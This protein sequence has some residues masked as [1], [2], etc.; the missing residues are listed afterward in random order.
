MD[1]ALMVSVRL[2]WLRRHMPDGHLGWL[3]WLVASH[4]ARRDRV[5][6]LGMCC[7]E[8]E[9]WHGYLAVQIVRHV[10]NVIQDLA[11]LGD[12]EVLKVPV[13][14]RGGDRDGFAGKQVL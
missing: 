2:T 10:H 5:S 6:S 4:C 11:H 1:T 3:H 13:R 9:R 14:R 12:G 7:G 8:R